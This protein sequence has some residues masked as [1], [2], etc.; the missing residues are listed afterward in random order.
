M[1]E[2]TGK[3][4]ALV[5]EPKGKEPL[6]RIRRRKKDGIL[7]DVLPTPNSLSAL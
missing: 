1:E 3:P 7:T 6:G 4:W 2:K 5:G